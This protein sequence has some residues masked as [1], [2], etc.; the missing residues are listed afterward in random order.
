[1]VKD[2]ENPVTNSNNRLYHFYD[3][4]HKIIHTL[5]FPKS[6][7]VRF[8]HKQENYSIVCNIPISKCEIKGIIGNILITTQEQN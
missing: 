5:K 8:P 7:H 1:M 2:S 3:L 6:F 4:H